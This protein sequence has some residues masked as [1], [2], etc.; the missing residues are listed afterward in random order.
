MFSQV[1]VTSAIPVV[2]PA[3]RVTVA[4]PELSVVVEVDERLPRF[5]PNVTCALA[6]GLPFRVTVAVI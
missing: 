4:T 3:E 5:V 6:T 1:A 2:G